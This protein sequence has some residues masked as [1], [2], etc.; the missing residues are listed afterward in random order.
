MS[1]DDDAPRLEVLRRLGATQDEAAELLAYARPAFARPGGALRLPLADEPF[2]AAWAAYAAEAR[3]RGAWAVLRDRLPQLRFPIAAGIS[4]T[5]A[6]RAAV[7][8]GE[9][10]PE[11]PGLRL[12]GPETLRLFLHRTRAGRV[13]VIVAEHRADFEALVRAFVARGEPSHVPESQGAVIVGGYN[14]WD[15]VAR[16]RAA[17]ERGELEAGGAATWTE[18]FAWVR[19]RKELYQD[20]FILLSGGPYSSVPAAEMGMGE[21]EWRRVS[22][23]IRLEHES[24]HY[25]TRRLLGAMRRSLHDELIADYAGIA[26]AAGRFRADWFLRFLGLE[27]EKYRPGGR[28]EI[29]RAGLSDGAFAVLQALVLRAAA[30]V[31][32]V[33]ARLPPTWRTPAGRARVMLALAA[34]PIEMLAAEDGTERLAARIHIRS[35]AQTA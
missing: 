12:E 20:C 14:N 31:E 8:R 35:L 2:V 7:R 22:L 24:A 28:L 5:P 3:R 16:L 11:G 9:P 4:E 33:D 26:T 25:F 1:D 21:A 13:P 15:R 29:Y 34:E 27:A 23:A 32:T 30:T 10:P 18:A 19:E 6:Y 17:F